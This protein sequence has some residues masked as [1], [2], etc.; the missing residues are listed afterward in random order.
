MAGWVG[1]YYDVITGVVPAHGL[2]AL[3]AL[4]ALHSV[5]SSQERSV[6]YALVDRSIPP[7]LVLR[8]LPRGIQIRRTHL[9]PDPLYVRQ[10]AFHL[11]RNSDLVISPIPFDTSGL[12]ARVLVLGTLEHRGFEGWVPLPCL[13]KEKLILTDDCPL[14]EALRYVASRE[15]EV[16]LDEVPEGVVLARG[17]RTVRT[18]KEVF[19][20]TG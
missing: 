4:L 14:E 12:S 6:I 15:V 8:Y 10:E 7:Q 17:T 13:G 16:R 1:R 11:A 18:P 20:P 5:V 3:H 19:P 2:H 9:P